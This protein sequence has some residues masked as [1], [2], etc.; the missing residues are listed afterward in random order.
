M[1]AVSDQT[2]EYWR[3]TILAWAAERLAPPQLDECTRSLMVDAAALHQAAEQARQEAL[4][5][6]AQEC[7]SMA[8]DTPWLDA[9][10]AYRRCGYAIRARAAASEG[11]KP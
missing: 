5:E 3:N 11:A 9:Q 6:A 7:D 1:D 4:E 2:R 8:N 10:R